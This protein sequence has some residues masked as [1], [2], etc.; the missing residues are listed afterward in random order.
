[1]GAAGLRGLLA[2]LLIT[3]SLFRGG[4]SLKPFVGVMLFVVI[5][6]LLLSLL[7]KCYQHYPPGTAVCFRLV[8]VWDAS[9]G[10]GCDLPSPPHA[11]RPATSPGFACGRPA[12]LRGSC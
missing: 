10:A 5:V 6:F 8:C 1:M 12:A 7:I 4:L 2:A 3:G 11:H 9:A